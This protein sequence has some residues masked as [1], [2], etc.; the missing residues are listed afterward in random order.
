MAESRARSLANLANESAISVDGTSFD[1]GISSASPSK[2][3][4]VGGKATINVNTEDGPQS[5]WDLEDFK[6]RYM[7]G[8]IPLI[9]DSITPRAGPTYGTTNVVVRAKR[10]G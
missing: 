5:S 6:A 7:K 1:V 9:L 10:I 8:E 4:D 2:E 3:L